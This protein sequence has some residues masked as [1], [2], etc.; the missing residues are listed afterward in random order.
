MQAWAFQSDGAKEGPQGDRVMALGAQCL[1]AGLTT[2]TAADKGCSLLLHELLLKRLKELLRFCQRQAE[3]LNALVGFLQD[4]DIG[5]GF[6]VA[7]VITYDELHFD[8]H[9]GFPPAG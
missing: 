7:I 4:D 2:G 9:E 8:L 1:A 6:F 5:V 3:L